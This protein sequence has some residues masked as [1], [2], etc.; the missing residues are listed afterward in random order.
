MTDNKEPDDYG[1]CVPI[2][3][4]APDDNGSAGCAYGI[5]PSP[6]LGMRLVGSR[7]PQEDI[8]IFTL[9]DVLDILEDARKAVLP[10][11]HPARHAAL[12]PFKLEIEKLM[13]EALQRE[14]DAFYRSRR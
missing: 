5:A 2:Y 1:S 7:V 14:I 10:T 3:G 13:R 9:H 6:P 12:E 11:I 4:D 8:P